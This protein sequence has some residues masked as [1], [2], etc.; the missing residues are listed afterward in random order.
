MF[1]RLNVIWPTSKMKT[2]TST[3]SRS[4]TNASNLKGPKLNKKSRGRLSK[5]QPTA[6]VLQKEAPLVRLPNNN[7]PIQAQPPL[8]LQDAKSKPRHHLL[9][10]WR[11]GNGKS[12]MGD[13]T[14]K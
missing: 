12:G 14:K 4:K 11:Q 7:N 6:R 8:E 1:P 2:G 10:A 9:V 13:G 5:L 3:E